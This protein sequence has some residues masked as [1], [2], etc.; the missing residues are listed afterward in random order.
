MY[1]L[2]TVEPNPPIE[3]VINS[4]VI[5]RLIEFLQRESDHV[6]QVALFCL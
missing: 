4:G 1:C 2:F 3:E 6:L 5:P